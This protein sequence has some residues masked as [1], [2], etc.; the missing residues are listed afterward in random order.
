LKDVFLKF[1][2]TLFDR[3]ELSGPDRPI[4]LT[5]KKLA[6]LLAYLACTAPLRQRRQT[7]ATLLWGSH[8]E[9][10]AQQ[11]LRQALFRLR[12]AL[13]PN[14][15]MSDNDE[16][17]LAPGVID[18]DVVLLA[19][20]SGD[21]SGPSLAVSVDL[22]RGSLLA[23]VD[24]AEEAWTDWLGAERRRLEGLALDTMIRYAEWALQSGDAKSALKAARRAIS[25]NTLRED[26]HR[27]IIQA[28]A[29]TGRKA[30]AFKHYQDLV[31]FLKREL[32]TEPD[33]AVRW[34]VAELR[35]TQPPSR[36][37]AVTEN[38]PAALDGELLPATRV[39][40]A[41]SLGS[42]ERRQ[43]TIMACNLVDPMA[44]SARLDPE[45]MRD[46]IA[47]FH[48]AV[49][50]V[51]SRFDGFVA[52]YLSDGVMVYFGYPAAHEHDTEQAVRAGLALVDA[53]GTLKAASGMG[54]QARVGIVTGLVVV[55]E[56]LEGGGAG[57]RVATGETP[58]LAA[59]LQAAAAPGEVVIAS[60]T[61]RLI[62]RMFH[63]RALAAID[64][65]G[66]PQSVEAWQVYGEAAGVSRFQ[67][68]RAGALSPLVGRQEEIG[69]LLRRWGRVKLGKGQ[70][71]LLS[72]D[73]GIGKS[74]IAESLLNWLDDA[75]QAP[76]RYFCSPHHTSS[77]L[78]P[79]IAQIERAAGF[80]PGSSAT[81]KLD[82]LEALLTPI[83]KSVPRDTALVAELLGIPAGNRYPALPVSSQQKREMTLTA[84]LDQLDGASAQ[85]S[86]LMVF[87]DLHWIDPTS[88]DLLARMVARIANLPVLLVV[89]TRPGVPPPWIGQPH[90]TML[91]L[92]RLD[93]RD[94]AG[95]IAGVT[96]D[97][98]LPDTVVEQ[99]LARADGVPLFIEE[100][101]SALLESGLLRETQDRYVLEGP[102]PTL[103]LPATLQASLT[104]RLDRLA[105]VKGVAQICAAIG[106]EFSH[107]LIAA[108][109]ALAATDLDAALERLI[110]SSLISR[111]GTPPDATYSFRH[112][113]VQDAA[114]A[115]MLRSRR[116]QL[117]ASIAAALV[118]RFPAMAER[119][120]EVVALHFT[121]A[122]LASEAIGYW[123]KAGRL[124]HA[125][126][127]N[128]EAV[129]SFEQAL[130]LLEAQ[131]KTRE[132]L[133]QA[134]DLRFELRTSLLPLGEFERIFS[135]LREA[136]SLA[137][138]LD[139]QRRLGQ[140]FVH[141][142]FN[143][144]V[145]GRPTEALGFGQGAQVIAESLGDVPLQVMGSL[146]LGVACIYTGDYRQAEDLFLKVLRLL[147]GDLSRER[148]G[149]A[150]FPAVTA[151]SF[152]TW[153]F[154]D[155][156]E[157]KKGI[158]HGQEGVRLAEA[159]DHPYSLAHAC[160]VLAHLRI[161]R[162]ELD[163][164]VDLLE[165]GLA[166]SS[167]WNLTYFSAANM[168]MLGY[169]YALSGRKAEGIVLLEQALSVSQNMQYRVVQ[170]QFLVF[171]GEAYLLADRLDDALECAGRA[172]ISARE[173]GQR[174]YEAWALRLLGE[175]NTRYDPPNGA[176][177]RYSGALVLA[178][179][180]GMRPL[181]AHCHFGLAK[182]YRRMS[183]P[184]RE[185]EHLT[186]ARAMYREM[187]MASWLRRAAAE[188]L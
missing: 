143:L 149:L 147:D 43:L 102:L 42:S 49:A 138:S 3:F 1:K 170:P 82:R 180:L 67:A 37:P 80:E 116:R 140:M 133:E 22:Y 70:V 120:P 109:S 11:N 107:E 26:A 68:R 173:G 141:M 16:V 51:V 171:L 31:A 127:A 162:G 135:Y 17:W 114:Y 6:A 28:L 61:H 36:P 8:F 93:R 111:R 130:H 126:W 72:G 131:P 29:A 35:N 24:I 168:G 154:T 62:G 63:C 145:T 52:Q 137:R 121:E 20:L 122:A 79:F 124:A 25:V 54:L 14:A 94:S 172:L 115:T 118:E 81:A 136:E 55:G 9:I 177:D 182:M 187:N 175:V 76:L 159:L 44:L 152:L 155:Q 103:A 77:P 153:V 64:V 112:A 96:R 164:A 178:E 87:E 33:A 142:C 74:R 160:W 113:L 90:V 183:M 46:L 129:A 125:R 100:L 165:R 89:T 91:T 150:G 18:S 166:L 146:Y 39:R 69:L 169:A 4:E 10:Q 184:E 132:A 38:G 57:Q 148:F 58:T 104:A 106:R 151:R 157:F 65:E 158:A 5:N 45:D 21:A 41:N 108:V 167:K 144:A 50:D 128:R 13:G 48:K 97:K 2:L 59:R 83:T 30:E 53:V 71:A 86:V 73:P 186:V 176:E 40:P 174:S 185:Q 134:I 66:L 139:D 156:A 47:S 56:Q 85:D 92:N 7:L 119:R 95:I 23:D 60:G 101:T 123:L 161:T 179:E 188:S 110:T 78:Y 27:L 117:H 88:Q 75:P 12:R 105:S 163:H 32:N 84:L 15:L 98:A 34:L 181:I 19:S 99:V